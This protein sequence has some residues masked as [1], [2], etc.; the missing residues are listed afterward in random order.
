M[1]ITIKLKLKEKLQ[2][3][4][5]QRKFNNVV[6]FSFNRAIDGMSKFDI[7]KLLNS[8]NNVEELDLTWKREATKLGYATALSA[9]ARYKESEDKKDLKVIFG[10]KFLFYK[11]LKGNITHDEY[12]AQRKLQPITC[13]GSKADNHGNRKF[14]FDFNTFEGIVKLGNE[15]VS[16]ACHKT[17]KKNMELLYN[18]Y[19]LIENKETGVTYKISNEYFYIVFDLEKLPKEVSYK[20]DKGTTLAL[21]INPN[22]IG[23]SIAKDGNV[24]FKKCYNLSQ[25]KDDNDKKKYELTQIAIDIKRLCVTHNVCYV[26][27]EKLKIKSSDKK[28]GRRFNRQVN[29]E[30]CR[31]Y[32]INSLKKHLTLIGCKY[33]ELAAQYS[34]FIGQIMNPD[35]TDSVAASIELNRRLV[36][37]KKQYIDKTEPRGSVVY[38]KFSSDYLNR[39]KKEG[40]DFGNIADWQAAYQYFKKSRHSYRFLYSDFVKRTRHEVFR[41]KSKRSLV[42]YIEDK[43][44]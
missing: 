41:L 10:G 11:R 24:T 1:V 19:E 21:D 22:Y 44:T 13:E 23:L 37:F 17:S 15:A 31:E 20:K 18:L 14:K 40:D 27:F 36:A 12:V 25:I 4:N 43:I 32:F 3:E 9:L 2:L 26:G 35:D 7:F 29:N 33:Q 5:F 8:L 42:T 16:F 6:R 38:P 39:W 34:S 30:W 28:K